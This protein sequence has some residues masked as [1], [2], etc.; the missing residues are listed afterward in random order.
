MTA[1][2]PELNTQELRKFGFT[3]GASR[4]CPVRIIAAVAV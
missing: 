3:T 1:K 4:S 2:T